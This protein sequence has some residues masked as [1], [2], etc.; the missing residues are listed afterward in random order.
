MAPF[1]RI[2]VDAV[3]RWSCKANGLKMKTNACT[4]VCTCSKFLE[5]K[6]ATQSNPTGKE[7]VQV[8]EDAW[9]LRC[10]KPVRIIHDQGSECS[11]IDFESFLVSQGIKG[12]PCTVENPQSNAVLEQVH[13]AIKTSQQTANPTNENEASSLIDGALASA[14][15]AIQVC[16]HETCDASPGSPVFQR[17]MLPPIPIVVNSHER[18]GKLSQTKTTSWKTVAEKI[19]TVVS[20]TND[21]SSLQA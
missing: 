3:G 5:F 9:L 7:S 6:K 11:D 14:Q 1:E 16:I 21:N 2:A 20:E 4:A 10:P 15:H 8:L 18:K 19:R 13:D 17:N 12:V